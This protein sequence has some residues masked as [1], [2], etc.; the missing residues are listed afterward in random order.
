[1]KT[2]TCF[3]TLFCLVLAAP[4]LAEELELIEPALEAADLLLE[5]SAECGASVQAS[6]DRFPEADRELLADCTISTTCTS[7]HMTNNCGNCISLRYLEA[8]TCEDKCCFPGGGCFVSG[9]YTQ[10]RCTNFPC[11]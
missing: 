10:T 7:W 9:E 6:V 8:R 5:G 2:L 4:A 11:P 3:V 1:M